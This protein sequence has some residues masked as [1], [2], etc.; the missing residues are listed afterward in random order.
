[1]DPARRLGHRLQPD[2]QRRASLFC[3]RPHPRGGPEPRPHRG[4]HR[5]GCP[6]LSDSRSATR[7]R[8][9]HPGLRRPLGPRR[10]LHLQLTQPLTFYVSR[11]TSSFRPMTAPIE[12]PSTAKDEIAAEQPEQ[13]TAR[14]KIGTRRP[15]LSLAAFPALLYSFLP[16]SLQARLTEGSV[17]H[18]VLS[19]AWPSVA[20][21]SLLTLVGLVDTYI[22]GHLGAEAI[23]G[24]GMGHIILNWVAALL[25]AIGVGATAVVA[26]EVGAKRTAE[27]NAV[28]GQGL[29]VAG[30]IGGI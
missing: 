16:Y 23:A 28:G 6:G 29:L 7:G 15:G 25:V 20:E 11:C 21:Q 17:T 2:A 30:V 4:P 13:L 27:A 3:A 24:V 22:V 10:A 19:L 26:R 12:P 9:A 8:N 14:L 18:R 1:M 5:R